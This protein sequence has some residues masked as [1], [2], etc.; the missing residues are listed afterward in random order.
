MTFIHGNLII[1]NSLS[2]VLSLG[3]TCK[4]FRHLDFSK[5]SNLT[6]TQLHYTRTNTH[7]YLSFMT[8]LEQIS[9][10]RDDK[11]RRYG[12]L[13]QDSSFCVLVMEKI[14]IIQQNKTH[15]QKP[16]T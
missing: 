5:V 16:V 4:I 3:G 10:Y 13:S 12:Q 9:R 1:R 7:T 8:H 11:D 6:K 15:K 14:I 2:Q